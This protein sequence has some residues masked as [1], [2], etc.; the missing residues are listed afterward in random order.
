MDKEELRKVLKK[1]AESQGFRLNPDEETVDLVLEGLLKNEERYGFRYCP[2]RVVSG[3]KEEDASKICPCKW[4]KE[5]IA[6]M[7]HCACGLFVRKSK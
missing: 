3:K 1:Y 7:G 5:E 2:C 6:T 4:H